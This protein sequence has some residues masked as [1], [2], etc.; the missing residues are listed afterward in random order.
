[1]P[2]A[3][4]CAIFSQEVLQVVAV[5]GLIFLHRDLCVCLHR[6]TRISTNFHVMIPVLFLRKKD[7]NY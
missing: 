2:C 3:R 1:M 4:M 6:R 5:K 7:K